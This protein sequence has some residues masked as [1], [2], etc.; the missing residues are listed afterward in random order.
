MMEALYLSCAAPTYIKVKKM[1]IA[2]AIP[3]HWY[4]LHLPDVA[5]PTSS[6]DLG[7]FYENVKREELLSRLTYGYVCLIRE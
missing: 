3:A 4:R 7:I 1:L 6:V 2:A 5:L